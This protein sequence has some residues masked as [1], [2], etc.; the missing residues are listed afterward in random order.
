MIQLV[1][2]SAIRLTTCLDQRKERRVTKH[3]F[4]RVRVCVRARVCVC[5][6]L[7]EY[8]HVCVRVRVQ[9]CVY[10]CSCVR[11][12][13]TVFTTRNTDPNYVMLIIVSP[14]HL[15]ISF[16]LRTCIFIYLILTRLHIGVDGVSIRLQSDI[17][18]PSPHQ[19]RCYPSRESCHQRRFDDFDVGDNLVTEGVTRTIHLHAVCDA[20]QSR[21]QE[22]SWNVEVEV[23]PGGECISV[24]LTYHVTGCGVDLQDGPRVV[25]PDSWPAIDIGLSTDNQWVLPLNNVWLVEERS[26]DT[27]NHQPRSF[28]ILH[29]RHGAPECRRRLA[30]V[31]AARHREGVH[32][33]RDVHVWNLHR[34]ADGRSSFTECR[35]LPVPERYPY[36]GVRGQRV[37]TDYEVLA[38]SRH[39][40]RSE[41][42]HT[43]SHHALG[44]DD[45]DVDCSRVI[46]VTG[47]DRH[48]IRAR[49]K[50]Q[51][52]DNPRGICVKW[53]TGKHLFFSVRF[54]IRSVILIM[55]KCWENAKAS[56]ALPSEQYCNTSLQYETRRY[57]CQTIA[58]CII[59][60]IQWHSLTT[61]RKI[62]FDVN[63]DKPT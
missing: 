40:D 9:H 46:R 39:G 8:V 4:V 48:S 57:D 19:G 63:I 7:C 58:N 38:L 54:L 31:V 22:P 16:Q 51:N 47:V 50:Y 25:S 36:V 14:W 5:V 26:E 20:V 34:I 6:C 59:D 15:W 30:H 24:H 29:H 61:A 43:G 56:P 27:L 3:V 37:E 21:R 35:A 45:V 23:G 2:G 33:G 18:S 1:S 44:D 55:T 53:N 32:T 62:L 12:Y 10:A 17:H 60:N 41:V 52:I 49:L 13:E 42:R 11:V 28:A